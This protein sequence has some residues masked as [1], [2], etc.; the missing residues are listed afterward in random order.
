MVSAAT[1]GTHTLLVYVQI[2]VNVHRHTGKLFFFPTETVEQ[3]NL[4]VF[5]QSHQSVQPAGSTENPQ[6]CQSSRGNRNHA[7]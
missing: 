3:R 7:L 4:Q 1:V 5:Q 2:K 6:N